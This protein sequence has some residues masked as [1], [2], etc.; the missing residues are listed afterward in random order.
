[1]ETEHLDDFHVGEYMT[2]S[3]NAAS[4]GGFLTRF[5]RMLRERMDNFGC[6]LDQSCYQFR[7]QGLLHAEFICLLAL[8]KGKTDY[9]EDHMEL[10]RLYPFPLQGS[11]G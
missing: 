8:L 1:M 11:N 3:C 10:A 9:S 7:G 6:I 4:G 5:D 2:R